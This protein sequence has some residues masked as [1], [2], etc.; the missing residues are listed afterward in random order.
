M[1]FA[2]K[3]RAKYSK[4]ECC[5]RYLK[6]FGMLG[7]QRKFVQ[8]ASGR[9]PNSWLKNLGHKF[10]VTTLA[11]HRPINSAKRAEVVENV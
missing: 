8:M 2:V 10:V 11:A 3:F 4:K 9:L 1:A 6:G 7:D 5:L